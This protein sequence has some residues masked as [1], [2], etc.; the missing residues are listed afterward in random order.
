MNQSHSSYRPE[1]CNRYKVLNYH[2]IQAANNR[3][4]LIY[5]YLL[6]LT[7][8]MQV[9]DY[10]YKAFYGGTLKEMFELSLAAEMLF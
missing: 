3:L 6:F 4:R 7:D 8:L 1:E 5:R 9:T 10:K 2:S